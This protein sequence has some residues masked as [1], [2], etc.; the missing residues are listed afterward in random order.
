MGGLEEYT[1]LVAQ[2]ALE[3][4]GGKAVPKVSA[5][6]TSPEGPETNVEHS[7]KKD[8]ADEKR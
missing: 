7:D 5:L 4:A 2:L 1:D 3:T 6:A 8:P